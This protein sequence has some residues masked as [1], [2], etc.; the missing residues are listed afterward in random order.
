MKFWKQSTVV[1]LKKKNRCCSVQVGINAGPPVY[2]TNVLPSQHNFPT[3]LTDWSCA[4]CMCP[5]TREEQPINLSQIQMQNP[6]S[7]SA[8]KGHIYDNVDLIEC[9]QRRS[10][11]M[12]CYDFLW[13]LVTG[14]S[15]S[16]VTLKSVRQ[17]CVM[18]VAF[19]K[20]HCVKL[21]LLKCIFTSHHHQ[22]GIESF[23]IIRMRYV[24]RYM[25]T[26]APMSLTS[27]ILGNYRHEV[28]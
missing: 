6:Q 5:L 2:K 16:H 19:V 1:T 27:V 28:L 25:K 20:T 7:K 18:V 11:W 8:T 22:W 15:N 24:W 21:A 3:I 17:E 10:D 12:W 14:S 9:E 26:G 23:V 4:Q 13:V